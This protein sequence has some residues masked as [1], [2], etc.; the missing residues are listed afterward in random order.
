MGGSAR[1]TRPYQEARERD[2]DMDKYKRAKR[3]NFFNKL[4]LVGY[5]LHVLL[6]LI[7]IYLPLFLRYVFLRDAKYD[8]SS[9]IDK[10]S[11]N[12]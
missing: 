6:Y 9:I 7:L 8:L 5:L 10:L 3:L 1:T 2:K 11:R 4:S 12:Y